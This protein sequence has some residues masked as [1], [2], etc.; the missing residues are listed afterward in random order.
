MCEYWDYIVN[1]TNVL[2][3]INNG[4][5]NYINDEVDYSF[6]TEEDIDYFYE[7]ISRD[8]DDIDTYA[9][10]ILTILGEQI[11]SSIYNLKLNTNYDLNSEW[12]KDF[13][14]KLE[15]GD[16]KFWDV[17]WGTKLKFSKNY[18]ENE[19][20][21]YNIKDFITFDNIID[22][23]NLKSLIISHL[24]NYFKYFYNDTPSPIIFL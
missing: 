13:K 5:E 12:Y 19:Y 10:Y 17:D 8:T 24:K 15:Y 22:S 23:T 4:I 18:I 21:D 14:N 9:D 20:Y 11:A 6:Y 1:N 16:G 7:V 2:K 3:L